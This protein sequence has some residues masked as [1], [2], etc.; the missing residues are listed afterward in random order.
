MPWSR[1]IIVALMGALTLSLALGVAAQDRGVTNVEIRVWQGVED[2]L[3]LFLSARQEG[4]S[5]GTLGTIPLSLDKENAARTLRFTDIVLTLEPPDREALLRPSRP[6]VLDEC[7]SQVP[8]IGAGEVVTGDGQ[9]RW[10]PGESNFIVTIPHGVKLIYTHETVEPMSMDWLAILGYVGPGSSVGSLAFSGLYGFE[11][12][13]E[14]ATYPRGAEGE[15]AVNLSALFDRI[16]ASVR[17]TPDWESC[18]PPPVG[19]RPELAVVSDGA[20]DGFLIEWSGGPE[21]ARHWQYRTGVNADYWWW[22]GWS[23]WKD[24]PGGEAASRSYRVTG[25]QA[26]SF[27]QVQV[28][29][30]V[31]GVGSAPSALVDVRTHVEGE[32]PVLYGYQTV[33]G[34]GRTEWRLAHFVITIPEGARVEPASFGGDDPCDEGW[35]GGRLTDPA[36][37]STLDFLNDGEEAGRYLKPAGRERTSELFDQIVASMRSVCPDEA[38]S[39][40]APETG[41]E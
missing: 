24:I 18:G 32:Y 25:L 36:S 8:Q 39:V 10:R 38:R 19:P 4:G 31:G 21:G 15:G 34:D 3:R 16:V 29:A 17:L 23:A 30:V 20:T 14:T 11:E 6:P 35:N 26:G 27:Y 40:E 1:V 9:T 28:R 13:R 5:W 37:G 22:G 7:T 2:P 12:S 41:G 33:V